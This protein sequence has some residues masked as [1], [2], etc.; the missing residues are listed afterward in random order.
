MDRIRRRSTV[1]SGDQCA[2]GEE[3]N[4]DGDACVLGVV[5]FQGQKLQ[6]PMNVT[7]YDGDTGEMYRMAECEAGGEVILAVPVNSDGS[8][9]R[10]FAKV[11]Y[12]EYTYD[13]DEYD[14]IDHWA[15]TMSEIQR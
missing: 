14:Y 5:R 13:E 4:K 1:N 15:S 8:F 7:T 9:K 11:Q 2:P 6:V 10:V 12:K 3:I